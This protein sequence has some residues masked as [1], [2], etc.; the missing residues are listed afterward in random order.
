MES[1]NQVNCDL[2]DKNKAE[3]VPFAV[4]E[5]IRATME[6]TVKRMWVTVIILIALLVITNGIWIWY[7]SQFETVT[8]SQEIANDD[9]DIIY[10]NNLLGEGDFYG[11]TYNDYGLHPSEEAGWQNDA[12]S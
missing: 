10:R 9:G 12:E 11:G 5:G 6:R 7:E 8:V 2:C 1:Y 4:H 3:P